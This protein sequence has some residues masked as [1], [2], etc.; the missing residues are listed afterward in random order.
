MRVVCSTWGSIVDALLPR[1]QPRGSA[2]V[3]K[4]KLGWYQSV[5]E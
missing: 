3:M 2:V 1:L 5:V 4:G